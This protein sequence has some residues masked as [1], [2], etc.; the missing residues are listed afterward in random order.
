MGL[1]ITFGIFIAIVLF[2]VVYSLREK[3]KNQGFI[4]TSL[5]LLLLDVCCIMLIKCDTM[6]AARNILVTYYVFYGW[7]FFGALL[8][9][10]LTHSKKIYYPLFWKKKKTMRI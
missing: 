8:T 9:I 1:I 6:K 7:L 5:V 4:I 2:S 3:H 10:F